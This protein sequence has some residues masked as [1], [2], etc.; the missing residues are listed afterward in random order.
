[1]SISDSSIR[2]G[3]SRLW[4]LSSALAPIALILASLVV[5]SAARAQ[6]TSPLSYTGT[7]EINSNQLVWTTA[8]P[9]SPFG[10][11]SD[12][13]YPPAATSYLNTRQIEIRFAV[14]DQSHYRVEIQTVQPAL[15]AGTRTVIVNGDQMW[16]YDS[17]T[18][19][20][21]TYPVPSIDPASTAPDPSGV[22][23]D[24]LLQGNDL[25]GVLGGSVPVLPDP[26]S[27]VDAYVAALQK[28]P[29]PKGV[30]R[31]AAIVGHDT[32]LGHPVDVIGYGPYYDGLG[33]TRLWVD[34]EHPFVLKSEEQYG[35]APAGSGDMPN[36]VLYRVTSINFGTGPSD[37]DLQPSFP[38]TPVV[39]DRAPSL[40]S[41]WASSG[42]TPPAPFLAVSAPDASVF[43][44]VCEPTS[45]RQEGPSFY[46]TQSVQ[47]LFLS[48][49]SECGAP[50]GAGPYVMVRQ[51]IQVAGM[52]SALQVG[53]PST[54]NGCRIWSG[55][56]SDSQTWANLSVGQVAIQ[57]TSNALSADQLTQYAANAV[58]TAHE[59][60]TDP[61]PPGVLLPP[62]TWFCVG[63]TTAKP[64]I[65][66][67]TADQRGEQCFHYL[68]QA[69]ALLSPSVQEIVP[70]GASGSIDTATCAISMK[71]TDPPG[72]VYFVRCPS[73][74]GRGWQAAWNGFPTA[75]PNPI[76]PGAAGTSK[77]S[78]SSKKVK[79][80]KSKKG[81]ARTTSARLFV[82]V[83]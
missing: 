21:A 7:A 63:G 42:S 14:R 64:S 3:P 73:A 53:S 16:V 55:T 39:L 18:N 81:H 61:N 30:T 67:Y 31:S 57:V 48:Q 66:L 15:E 76:K 2:K 1:M 78:A 26:S 43:Q 59:A 23:N 11:G 34:A 56:Y 38:V 27:T 10:R 13:G 70:P 9:D 41:G 69:V 4:R 65:T 33:S 74:G 40:S 29:A 62:D 75:G 71:G 52:P 51:H 37:S 47:Q 8:P 80:H 24:Q 60:T 83:R 44:T 19:T 17:R 72:G 25:R 58:C 12:E 22:L 35:Q 28:A 5:P 54:I 6:V 45:F 79:K 36:D 82:T 32:F 49:H 46:G 68:D 77:K 50:V 20:A